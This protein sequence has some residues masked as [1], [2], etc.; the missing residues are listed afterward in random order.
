M[1]Q[2]LEEFNALAAKY[3]AS[4]PNGRYSGDKS[5]LTEL[6]K[7]EPTIKK[8]LS[9]LDPNLPLLLSVDRQGGVAAAQSA[10]TRGLGI[11]E[12]MDEWATR[13]APEAPSLPA[14]QLHP[15]VWDA[16]RTFWE[17]NHYRAAVHA[18]ATSINAHLQNKLGRR[19]LSD[20]K[21]IQEA[22]SDKAPEP[23]KARLRM[24]GDVTDPGV[25][26]RQRGTLQLGQGA[27]FA[28]RNP[29]AHESGELAEQE[30][31]EQLATFSALARLLDRCQVVT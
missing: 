29:A 22:L 31:L 20:A 26:T 30:A 15:W 4:I 11:C 2:R 16:A 28:F 9:C 10:V 17:S 1:R 19:D 6:R 23:G 7:A 21:L 5:L 25:Q 18:A 12:D 8:I 14:D 27:Y 24:P 3:R 13:L